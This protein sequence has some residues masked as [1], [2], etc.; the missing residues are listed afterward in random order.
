MAEDLR[1]GR[2]DPPRMAQGTRRDSSS[3][4]GGTTRWKELEG[5]PIVG[6]GGDGGA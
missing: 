6:L 2:Q 5:V 1:K 4:R 3:P